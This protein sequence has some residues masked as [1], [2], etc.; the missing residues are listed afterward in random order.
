VVGNLIPAQPH[1]ARIN[2]AE[3]VP[4][5][6]EVFV[7]DWKRR[8]RVDMKLEKSYTF[9]AGEKETARNLQI[10]VGS[11]DY[12]NR[13][14][15][16]LRSLPTQFSLAQNAPNPFNP[17]TMIQYALPQV[18]GMNLL[19]VR[20]AVYDLK[21][22]LVKTLVNQKQEAGYYYVRWNGAAENGRLTATGIYFYR[23]SVGGNF[24]KTLKMVMIK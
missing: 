13:H 1:E 15:R 23:I 22:Q 3:A 9:T 11:A 17:V 12:V 5:A 10:L 2:G 18:Q 16:G 4:E 8:I 19:P 14:T 20:L 24:T 6:T 7:A 21:G